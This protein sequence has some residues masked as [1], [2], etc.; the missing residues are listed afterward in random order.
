MFR[1]SACASTSWRPLQRCGRRDVT[2]VGSR[3]CG[4]VQFTV[5]PSGRAVGDGPFGGITEDA[6]GG[7][8][9]PEDRVRTSGLV[10]AG[11]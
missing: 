9:E 8:D 11:G 5:S 6:G 10:G 1:T 7:L 4:T 2:G 3:L